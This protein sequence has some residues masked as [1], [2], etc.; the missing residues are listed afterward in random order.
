[1]SPRWRLGMLG[2]A[3]CAAALACGGGEAPRHSPKSTVTILYDDPGDEFF[4]NPNRWHLA[5]FPVFLTLTTDELDGG[6][7]QPR[8]ASRWE[9]SPDYREW[10][11][12]LRPDVKWHD[13]V[14]VTARDVKFTMDLWAHPDVLYP[15]GSGSAT[16]LD[17]STLR[18]TYRRP[19][20]A[21]LN[22]WNVYYPKHLLENLDPKDF[23][24]WEFWKQ[25]VGNGA[26]RVARH[27]PRTLMELEANPNYCCG[28]PRI[29]RAVLKFAG[30]APL[31]ELR[32]GN[33][34]GAQVSPAELPALAGDPRFEAYYYATGV[35]TVH[36]FWNHRN[37]LFEQADI[38]RALTLAIDRRELHRVLNLPG[39]LPITDG[40]HTKRQ[41]RRGEIAPAL[42]YDPE[43]AKRLLDRAGWRAGSRSGLRE[44]NGRAFQFTV[45][46]PDARWLA[47][48]IRAA[49]FI[50][51]QL[52]RIGIRM[53]IQQLE[54][55]DVVGQR[56]ADGAFEA[57]ITHLTNYSSGHAK[58]FGEASLI[59]YARPRVT[60]L[61]RAAEVAMDLDEQDR[62]YGELAEIFHA[63]VPVTFLYPN[64]EN[65]VVDRRIRGLKSP[66]GGDLLWHLAELWVEK[67]VPR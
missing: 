54:S 65:W 42:P 58:Y 67:E 45:I 3:V 47:S 11:V 38:R 57:A 49:T 63:D 19:S 66:Y 6:D 37:A 50:Q 39:G 24:R 7:P 34:N 62:I 10:T 12:H 32:S 36:L 2:T 43:A 22:G 15:G 59:R 40:I 5:Q 53:E 28:K 64:V 56:I 29:E 8:L 1:M 48:P 52:R 18:I 33:V 61:L 51:D 26:Y 30:G 14:P 35:V 21:P 17:D 44:R 46:V 60:E 27:V 20:R 55:V 4:L 23:A 25:P 9:H 13:G 31:T 41:Y 16:V